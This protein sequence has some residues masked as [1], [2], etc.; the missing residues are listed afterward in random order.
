MSSGCF[1][2][3]RP[4]RCEARRQRGGQQRR[5]ELAGALAEA[6]HHLGRVEQPERALG[7]AASTLGGHGDMSEHLHEAANTLVSSAAGS[8]STPSWASTPG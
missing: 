2:Q 7:E 4:R 3:W 1:D 5:I 8:M 6:L